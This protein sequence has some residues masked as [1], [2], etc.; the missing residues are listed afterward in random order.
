M[1]KYSIFVIFGIL[2]YL[3]LNGVDGFSIGVPDHEHRTDRQ[4]GTL[5][6][7]PPSM[8]PMEESE[9]FNKGDI[10]KLRNNIE[11]HN[12]LQNDHGVVM[13]EINAMGMKY[14]FS[15]QLEKLQQI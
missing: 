9:S 13:N 5:P 4:L 6:S 7:E 3:F 2:L 10:V 15:D 1:Y 8:E 12:L 14:K 11:E